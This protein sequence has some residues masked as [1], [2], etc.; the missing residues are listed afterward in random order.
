MSLCVITGLRLNAGTPDF[1]L[2]SGAASAAA[3]AVVL[4]GSVLFAG[5]SRG[6]HVRTV[7][8]SLEPISDQLVASDQ[9]VVVRREFDVAAYDQ[10]PTAEQVIRDATRRAEAIAVVDV[11]SAN[12]ILVENGTWI[13]T[14]LEGVVRQVVK[15]SDAVRLSKGKRAAVLIH[16]GTVRIKSVLVKTDVQPQ[17]PTGHSYLLFM[18]VKGDEGAEASYPPLLVRNGTLASTRSSSASPEPLNGMKLQTAISRINA[19]K[20]E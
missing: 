1:S 12:S 9:V 8:Y 19:V 14:K 18:A 20:P 2:L 15:S 3:L 10:P 7:P 13:R 16:G 11:V 17:V 4:L 6:E 5:Q